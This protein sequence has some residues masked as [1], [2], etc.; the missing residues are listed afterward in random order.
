VSRIAI[1]IFPTDLEGV[2]V[3]ARGRVHVALAAP[4]F[5]AIAFAA[6]DLSPRLADEPGWT[7]TADVL[8]LLRWAVVITAAGTLVARVVLPLR[9]VAFG[10]VERLLYATS[11][12]WLVLVAVKLALVAG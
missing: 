8:E 4:A 5:A 2:A 7:G 9:R 1:A 12:A 11:I 6:S 3:T 10:A